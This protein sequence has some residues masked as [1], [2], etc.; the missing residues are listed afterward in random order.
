MLRERQDQPAETVLDEFTQRVIN[1][2]GYR[3]NLIYTKGTCFVP[4][5]W[6]A[7]RR[8]CWDCEGAGQLIS[9]GYDSDRMNEEL[10]HLCRTQGW[11]GGRQDL[12]RAL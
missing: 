6:V 11:I 10:C 2:L 5:P 3:F 12:E 1:Y 9:R 7:G 8:E 4:K